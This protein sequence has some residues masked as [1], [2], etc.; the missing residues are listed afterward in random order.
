M[1][2]YPVTF[3]NLCIRYQSCF[4]DASAIQKIMSSANKELS[5]SS[6]YLY[7]AFPR[8]HLIVLAKNYGAILNNINQRKEPRLAPNLRGITCN[9]SP[10]NIML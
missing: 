4:I 5:V 8:H 10:L 2:L 6:L 3:L 9:I 7:T 1:T